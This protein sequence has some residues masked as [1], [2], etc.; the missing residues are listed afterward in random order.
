MRKLYLLAFLAFLLNDAGAQQTNDTANTPY[1]LNMMQNRQVNFFQTVRAFNI[2]WKGRDSSVK[3]CGWKPFK[4]WEWETRQIINPDGTY[5][6]MQQ[7]IAQYHAVAGNVYGKYQQG[8]IGGPGNGP[9]KTKGDWKEL[10]PGFLPY[11]RTSQPGG[12]GRLNAVAFHP[13]DSNTFW[14]CA[15]AG[16]LWKTTNGGASWSSNTDSLPT[17]GTSALVISPRNTDT[18]YLGTG[19]RDHG[20]AAGLGVYMSADAGKTWVVRNTGMGNVTVSRM[21]I[22][23]SNTKI[24]LVASTSGVYRTTNSGSTWTQI[25]SGNFKDIVYNPLNPNTVFATRDGL[26]FRST[27]GGLT[28]TQITSGLPTSGVYRGAIGVTA[29]DTNY[30][31]FL[32][33]DFTRYYGTY[34][35]VNG[36]VSFS[37]RSTT[38]NVMDYSTNGSGSG[39]QA[40]YDLDIACDPG[41]RD[42]IFVGGINIFRSTDGAA[43]WTISAHWIGSSTLPSVH[44]DQHNLEYSPVSKRLY[45]A[46]DGGIFYTINNGVK[47]RDLSNGIGVSQLYKIGISAT[48]KDLMIGGFQDNGT[49]YF[50][51]NDWSGIR[52]GDGM[53]CAWDGQDAN[54]SYGALYY[55]NITRFYKGSHDITVANNGVGGINETGDWVTPYCLRKDN[56]ATMFVGYKNIWRNT[57]IKGGT[58]S[59][60]NITNNGNGNNIRCVENSPAKPGILYYSRYDN[61]LFRSYNANGTASWVDISSNLPVT[62]TPSAITCHPTDSNTVY[63]GL[64]GKVYRS[65]NRGINWTDISTGLPNNIVNSI[66]LDTSNSKFGIYVGTY[67]GVWF[68]DSTTTFTSFSNGLPINGNITDLEIFY[69]KRHKSFHRLYAASFSRGTWKTSLWDDGSKK[70]KTEF[71]LKYPRVCNSKSY[72][73]IPE[74]GYNPSR[75]KW[76]ITPK[77]YSYINNTDSFSEIPT[78]KFSKAGYYTVRL[79][80]ENCNGSDTLTKTNY[81]VVFDSIATAA[82]C[83]TSTS[84]LTD[85]FGIGITNVELNGLSNPSSGAYDEGSNV[86]FSCRKVFFLKPGGRYFTRVTTGPYYSEYAKIYIDYNNNG[87]FTDAGEDVYSSYKLTNHADTIRCP[88]N[89]VKNKTLRMRVVSDYNSIS[90]SCATLS[91]GQSEDYGVYFD[92]PSPSF[93]VS[94][95]SICENGKVTIQNTTSGFGYNYTWN[96]GSGALPATGTGEGP[97]VVQYPTGGYKKITLT[98]NGNLTK[99]KDSAVKVLKV[100]DVNVFVKKGSLTQCEYDSITLA[101]RDSRSVAGKYQWQKNNTNIGGA[102]DS[103]LQLWYNTVSAGG[104]YRVI[105]SN[106]ICSDTSSNVVYKVNPKPKAGYK[107]NSINQCLK[108]NNFIVTDT[109]KILSGSYKTFYKYSNG[110]TDTNRNHTKKFSSAGFYALQLK[111]TSDFGCTDSIIR[112]INVYPQATPGFTVNDTG[113]CRKGNAFVM[114]NTSTIAPGNMFTSTWQYGNGNSSFTMNGSQTYATHGTYSVR[115]TTNTNFNCKDTLVKTVTVFPTPVASFSVNDSTQCLRGNRFTGTN[116]STVATGTISYQ[117]NFGDTTSATTANVVKTYKT[118]NT[119]TVMLKT[120]SNEG[121]RDSVIHR[122]EVYPMPA[123]GF[124][125]DDSSQ[126][127]PLNQF[128]FTSTSVIT[129][130][131][132]SHQWSFGNGNTALLTNP[133]QS[134]ASTGNYNIRLITNSNNACADTANAT[135]EVFAKPKAQFTAGPATQCFK[136]NTVAIVN[137]SVSSKKYTVLFDMGDTKTDTLNSFNYR[138]TTAGQYKILLKTVIEPGCEDTV[139]QFVNII[140]SPVAGFNILN[141]NSCSKNNLIGFSNTSTQGTGI[142][143]N[144]QYGDNSSSTALQNS[145]HYNTAGSYPVKLIVTNSNNCKDTANATV[146]INESPVAGFTVNSLKQCINTN[147]FAF[148]NQSSLSSG[149]LTYDWLLGDGNT[150]IITSPSHRYSNTGNPVIRLIANSNMNCRDTAFVTVT[151]WAK[152]SAAFNILSKDPETREFDAINKGYQFYAWTINNESGD[153]VAKFSRTFLMNSNYTTVLIVTDSNNCKDT[154]TRSFL[155]YSPA[156]KQI[157]NKN[158]AYVYPNP[159]STEAQIKFELTKPGAIKYN[160]YDVLG[161][162]IFTFDKDNLPKGI[163]VY[164]FDFIKS[165][166]SQGTYYFVLETEEGKTTEKIIFNR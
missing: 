26:F 116:T 38:P 124:K 32:I 147:Q 65:R 84:I 151:V 82:N 78:I 125:I 89:M 115:L 163:Y 129:S 97:F 80:T 56:S 69:D 123:A 57:N 143:Y 22:H 112:L 138:Y 152:P 61:K 104:N 64:N 164:T 30:V 58:M 18:M 41:N 119:F 145:H 67:T 42:V 166:L 33:T 96:F 149:T 159:T 120:I 15:P 130:G 9:C 139:S 154:L 75:F 3:G 76:L 47:W 43:T 25:L 12:V 55:G 93:S 157:A 158:N 70:P 68:K 16:G 132:L 54:Y 121:C 126:C 44:A 98:I 53:D 52:G 37:T 109:S 103:M 14:V 40:W 34:R 165:G 102:T 160:V 133:N 63:I 110:S 73:L 24:L 105:A 85:N 92:E 91:Y 39:G 155:L 86:D 17:L 23:P 62:G 35:S 144:W 131:T 101:G 28:F 117:W 72:S 161:Q 46:N 118:P 127:L 128:K 106:S 83:K 162:L 135:I 108:G 27:N 79:A 29:A 88:L 7:W 51:G 71:Y 20:D 10:G 59:W 81:I 2:Y 50:N 100:P 134:Y 122:M 74:C 90:G 31:Y 45:V 60:T 95:D 11:N 21:L 146:I 19:D 111:V 13:T 48:V 87:V 156:L 5:P 137:N 49:S 36:G 6:D 153:P 148:T 8:G 114:T 136:G 66:A 4:R 94:S 99:A 1:Y 113:Q 107:I 150:S 142:A 141:N 140:A 77:T